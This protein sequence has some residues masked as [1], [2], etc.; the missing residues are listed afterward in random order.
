MHN[1]VIY[2]RSK[3]LFL[4]LPQRQT[5]VLFTDSTMSELRSRT[6]PTSQ[7]SSLHFIASTAMGAKSIEKRGHYTRFWADWRQRELNARFGADRQT[8]TFSGVDYL[9]AW[10]APRPPR[11][12]QRWVATELTRYLIAMLWGPDPAMRKSSL[13]NWDTTICI[14]FHVRLYRLSQWGRQ[15][16]GN[17]AVYGTVRYVLSLSL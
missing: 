17:L 16:R 11:L 15:V 13:I 8:T 2:P 4:S 7:F 9:T 3:G 10:A 1:D 12:A 14:H 6:T 5:M